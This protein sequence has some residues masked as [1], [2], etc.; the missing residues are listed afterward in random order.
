[1]E[2]EAIGMC[3]EDVTL[4]HGCPREPF[5]CDYQAVLSLL[6][7]G[8]TYRGYVLKCALLLESSQMQPLAL[9]RI[10][11]M[12]CL[13]SFGLVTFPYNTAIH[14]HTVTGSSLTNSRENLQFWHLP[15]VGLRN[16]TSLFPDNTGSHL[17]NALAL[18]KIIVIF[19]SHHF[20]VEQF[21]PVKNTLDCSEQALSEASCP[22]DLRTC[23]RAGWVSPMPRITK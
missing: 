23:A 7:G 10:Y 5:H 1:M 15:L 21:C 2:R 19:G 6:S 14:V 16:S 8:S 9:L 22:S 17:S 12:L 4:T 20:S 3:L 13:R 11:W 18:V